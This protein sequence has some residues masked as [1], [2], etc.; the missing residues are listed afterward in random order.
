MCN[1]IGHQ[2]TTGG[3]LII[4]QTSLP[5]FGPGSIKHRED[6]KLYNTDKERSLF[7]PQDSYYK[8]L[9]INCVDSGICI[10]LF[11]FPNTYIDIATIGKFI[12]NGR[13]ISI[14][15]LSNNIN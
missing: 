4:F 7:G 13:L 1:F 6:P 15:F 2:N 5:T 14:S 11:L 10:D 3:K 9:A 8:N 12:I